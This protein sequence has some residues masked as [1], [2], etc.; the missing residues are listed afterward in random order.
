MWLAKPIA[1]YIIHA[2]IQRN[3]SQGFAI[4]YWGGKS[5]VRLVVYCGYEGLTTG[6]NIATGMWKLTVALKKP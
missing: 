2:C 6:Q 4:I 3:F 5:I 1:Y